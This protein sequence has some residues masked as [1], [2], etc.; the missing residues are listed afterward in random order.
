MVGPTAILTGKLVREEK[1]GAG[2]EGV[3]SDFHSCIVEDSGIA[4]VVETYTRRSPSVAVVCRVAVG[5]YYVV[6]RGKGLVDLSEEISLHLVVCVEYDECI[7]GIV[8]ALAPDVLDHKVE[9]VSLTDKLVVMALVDGSAKRTCRLG[10]IVGAVV[11]GD[12]DIITVLGII[13][14]GKSGY[15]LSDDVLL[16]SRRNQNCELVRG[17]VGKYLA[18]F[19]ISNEYKNNLIKITDEEKCTEDSV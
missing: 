19:Q 13:L 4:Q 16:V 14:L 8:A 6:S 7:V 10:G 15:E 18:L 17:R 2:K 9:N 12:K 1:A 5:G 3:A 11:C